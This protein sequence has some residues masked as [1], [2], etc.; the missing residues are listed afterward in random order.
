MF[1]APTK[2]AGAVYPHLIHWN[3]SLVGLFF[4][5]TF[6]HFGHVLDVF[7]GFTTMVGTPAIAALYSTNFLNS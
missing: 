7:F 5:V 1:T 4:F 6:R 3:R 2:S